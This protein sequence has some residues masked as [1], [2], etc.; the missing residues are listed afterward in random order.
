MLRLKP[1]M[2]I[3]IERDLIKNIRELS[4]FNYILIEN[5]LY[6]LCELCILNV[7]FS[8]F[9]QIVTKATYNKSEIFEF[10]ICTRNVVKKNIQSFKTFL[11]NFVE[12]DNQISSNF[13][14]WV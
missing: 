8:I 4:K 6:F 9:F 13:K 5:L 3:K 1:K 11:L 7:K 14:Q 10:N 2:L 12:N